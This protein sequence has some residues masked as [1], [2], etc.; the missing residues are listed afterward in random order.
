MRELVLG[1]VFLAAVLAATDAV[2]WL[3]LRRAAI[4]RRG[5]A[6]GRAS[7]ALFWGTAAL[8]PPLLALG[9]L[10]AHRGDDTVGWGII[11]TLGVLYLPKLLLT[12]VGLVEWAATGAGRVVLRL[13]V[14]DPGRRDGLDRRL[15]GFH[16]ISRLGA[17]LAAALL[18]WF[19]YGATAGRNTVRVHRVDVELAHL[20]EALDGLVIAHVS[21]LHLASLESRPA[22]VRRLLAAVGDAHADLVVCTGDV[23][24]ADRLGAGPEILARV[25]A[26]LGAFAVAGN[27]DFGTRELAQANWASSE[28]RDRAVEALRQA[29]AARGWRLLVNESASVERAGARLTILGTGVFDPHHGY[30]DSD[31]QH[32]CAGVDGSDLRILLT[33][34]PELWDREVVGHQSVELTLAGHTHG[35]Q[36][37]LELGPLSLSLAGLSERRSMG[38]YREGE[39]ALYVNR[40][41]GLYGPPFRAG[42]PAELALIRLVRSPHPA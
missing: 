40:G 29:Y 14:S 16:G 25:H 41:V 11:S 42:I 39:Q 6:A 36:I 24:P 22:L 3:A 7:A 32:T 15:V 2:T 33:H 10:L 38:L 28:A 5:S 12:G 31:L 23:A 37:G 17:V 35:G 1:L 21:D 19:L 34:N 30:H 26:P 8:V 20:P 4:W 27:H 18:A 13:V 9:L